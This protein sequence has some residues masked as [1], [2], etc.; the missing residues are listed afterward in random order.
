MNIEELNA[1]IAKDVAKPKRISSLEREIKTLEDTLETKQQE[2]DEL[3]SN[4]SS[5]VQKL[6]QDHVKMITEQLTKGE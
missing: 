5:M 2:L 6:L 3:K 1:E 4:S